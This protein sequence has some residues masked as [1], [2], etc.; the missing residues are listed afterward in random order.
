MESDA[1]P[2]EI[3]VTEAKRLLDGP[4]GKVELID[5]REPFERDRCAIEGS[6][7]IP[8]QQI[9]EHLTTLS[10]DR[11]LLI[12]CHHGGRSL[13]VTQ[14]LRSQGFSRVSNVAGGI[15]A[16]AQ[17]IDPAMARY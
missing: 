1:C 11:H 6:T 8:M 15:E 3:S 7:F 4:A 16:W 17:E 5:I 9:P 13:R 12:H 14:Y 10:K 2:L